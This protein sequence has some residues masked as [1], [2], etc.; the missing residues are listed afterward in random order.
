MLGHRREG[1]ILICRQLILLHQWTVFHNAHPS[2]HLRRHLR[3]RVRLNRN[4]LGMEM[5]G[6]ILIIQLCHQL[7]LLTLKVIT[8]ITELTDPRVVLQVPQESLMILTS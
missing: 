5:D 4:Q 1:S 2:E 6:M 3:I 8:A 7:S